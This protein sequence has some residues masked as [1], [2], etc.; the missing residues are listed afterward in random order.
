MLAQIADMLMA[1]GWDVNQDEDLVTGFVLEFDH[2]EHRFPLYVMS[3]EVGNTKLIRFVVVPF[4]EQSFDGYPTAL[5]I[6]LAQLNHDLPQLKFAIDAD[7]DLELIFDIPEA[8]WTETV[9]DEVLDLLVDYTTTYFSEI[10][11][12][13]ERNHTSGAESLPK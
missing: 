11:T 9:L 3:L 12:I 13:V 4:V 7:G 2:V 1:R 8:Q 6:T 10:N 5:Y